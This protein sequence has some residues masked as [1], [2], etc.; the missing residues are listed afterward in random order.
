V[1]KFSTRRA[2]RRSDERPRDE[3]RPEHA[4]HRRH[5][6]CPARNRRGCVNFER[7]VPAFGRPSSRGVTDAV[8]QCASEQFGRHA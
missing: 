2:S 3:N 8:V 4:A 7:Q 6:N 5:T 1:K